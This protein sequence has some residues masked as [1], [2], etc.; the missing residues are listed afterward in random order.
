[1]YIPLCCRNGRRVE[2]HKDLWCEDQTL[3]EAFPI[4]FHLA[5]NK[6]AWVSNFWQDNRE[7]GSWTP[8]LSRHFND[9]EME[10]VGGFFRNS[11]L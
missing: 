4:L 6:D 11:N 2:F 5:S 3:E 1:M 7:M 9:W 8:H 10:E